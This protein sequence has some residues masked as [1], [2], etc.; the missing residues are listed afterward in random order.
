MATYNFAPNPS[1]NAAANQ[2]LFADPR[3]ALMQE[4]LKR[5][6]NMNNWMVQSM[7]ARNEELTPMALAYGAG[8]GTFED[9]VNRYLTGQQQRGGQGE[10]SQGD[11]NAV[12]QGR[13]Q[14]GGDSDFNAWLGA[15]DKGA[16][17]EEQFNRLNAMQGLTQRMAAPQMAKART[18][19]DA[20]NFD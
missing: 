19:L 2:T 7:L 8:A 20:Q 6:Y 15:V 10:F 3:R 18:A 17:P 16:D 4:M 11:I 1:S 13:L 14:S 12:V 5:G 9:F